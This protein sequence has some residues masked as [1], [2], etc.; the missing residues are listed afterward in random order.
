MSHTA[1]HVCGARICLF[2]D[3]HPQLHIVYSALQPIAVRTPQY[4]ENVTRDRRICCMFA[5]S[6][7]LRHWT[8]V[9]LRH[10]PSIAQQSTDDVH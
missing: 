10:R 3:S 9:R 6:I 7:A 5:A 2:E 8:I 1:R 4:S